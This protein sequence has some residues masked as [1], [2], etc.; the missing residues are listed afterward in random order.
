MVSGVAQLYGNSSE[1]DCEE[2]FN[3]LHLSDNCVSPALERTM[4]KFMDNGQRDSYTDFS[5]NEL[6][7]NQLEVSNLFY[8]MNSL[9]NI[10]SN[11]GRVTIDSSKFENINICGS[12]LKNTVGLFIDHNQT[13]I[14]GL[15]F[16]HTARY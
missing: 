6:V 9:I 5:G 12:I 14:D 10:T 8:E 1:G 2:S 3:L 16:Y 15:S 11:G 7:T 4:F 13:E